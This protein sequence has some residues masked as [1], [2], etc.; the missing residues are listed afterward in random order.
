M[1][2]TI[3]LSLLFISAAAATPS[4]A[5]YFANPYT[6]LNLNVG[7]APS[8]T[9]RDLRE[10]RTPRLGHATPAAT[11]ASPKTVAADKKPSQRVASK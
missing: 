1:R 5:N 8:P 7:S 11:A 10:N 9:P 6:G 2:T 4:F 3:A